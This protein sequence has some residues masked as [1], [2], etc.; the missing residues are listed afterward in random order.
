MPNRMKP[1]RMKTKSVKRRKRCSRRDRGASR[2]ETRTRRAARPK[3]AELRRLLAEVDALT[4]CGS[5][6]VMGTEKEE[7]AEE[8]AGNG[9]PAR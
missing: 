8:A 6:P 2:D 9:R 7:P 1:T 4:A 3:K 5:M